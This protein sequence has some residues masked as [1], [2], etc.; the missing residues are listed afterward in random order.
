MTRMTGAEDPRGPRRPLWL[1]LTILA[2]SAVIFVTLIGLGNWQVRRL[3]WKRDLIE[4]VDTRAFA[5]PVAAPADPVAADTHS[6]LRVETQGVYRHDLS[7]RVKAVTDL[8]PGYWV[9]T[10]LI[11]QG[12][13]AP[14]TTWINRGF[15]PNGLDPAEWTRPDGP[16]RV[17]G[18][19][20][21][22]EPDGTL[23]ERNDPEAGRWVS[24]DVLALSRE[25]G[26]GDTAG[27]F[28]DADH[29]GA[30][31]DWPRGGLTVIHFRNSHLSYALT[32]FAMALLFLGA[33][34]YVI[35]D[36]LKR[37]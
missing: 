18:L 21:L 6:Y 11:A 36:R 2:L 9:M 1:D 32:W 8:G 3:H 28:I 30:P 31:A 33:M 20:R 25:A 13:G 4:A 24:R 35:R 26:L 29:Q 10:P 12:D 5:A 23:M 37:R 34:V 15:V 22:T 14:R 7:Q 19:L 17:E 27:Y 16:Q